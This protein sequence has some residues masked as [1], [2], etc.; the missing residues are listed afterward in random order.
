MINFPDLSLDP[1]LDPNQNCI[2]VGT[3]RVNNP[4]K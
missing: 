3:S 4:I 1:E 2:I